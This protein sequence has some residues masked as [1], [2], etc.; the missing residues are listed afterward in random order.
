M[1]RWIHI[2]ESPP[3]RSDVGMYDGLQKLSSPSSWFIVFRKLPSE[4]S[5]YVG[6]TL[7]RTEL[8]YLTRK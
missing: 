6:N 2:C 5:L 3:D 7:N 8:F 1:G 4:V